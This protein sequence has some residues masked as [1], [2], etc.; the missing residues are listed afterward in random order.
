[1]S[2][3]SEHD[4][5]KGRGAGSNPDLR[6]SE[7]QH[8]LVDDGWDNLAEAAP[9]LKTTLSKD[10]SRS[11]ITYNKSPDVG[12]DRSINPYRG[13]EHGCVYCF[14]RPTHAYLDLSPGLD[15]ESR[16]FYKPEAPQLLRQ[17][18][19]QRH[20]RCAPIAVGIITD[21]YQPVERKLG[22]TRSLLEILVETRHPFSIVTK[23]ALIE[24]DIDL[25]SLAAQR[26]LASVAV[27]IT[28]LDRSLAR[29]LE[30]RAAAPQRRLEVIKRLSEAGI[31]VTVLIAPV[32]PVLTDAELEEILT[33]ARAAGAQ[34]AGYVLL[35]LPLEVKELFQQWLETHE[36]LKAAHVMSRMRASRGGKDYDARFGHR[37][38]GEGEFAELLEQRFRLASRRLNFSGVP[39]LDCSL[40]TAPSVSKQL[41]LFS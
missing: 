2:H 9:P 1:M 26:R 23:S 34:A 8:E 3:K 38:K 10:S 13:C 22:L 7:Y 18:L 41:S 25:I 21:A 30:P 16:L 19:A 14:A 15:F 37:M 27:S 12:F 24:R 17:E 35:R 4:V 5:Y 6:F 11:I 32:I 28:T 33:Q 39:D 29:R 20:Y 36:P 40:F 31:P